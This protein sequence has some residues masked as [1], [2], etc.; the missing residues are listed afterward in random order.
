MTDAGGATCH[1]MEQLR[2]SSQ[3]RLDVVSAQAASM[4]EKLRGNAGGGSEG[5][6]GGVGGASGAPRLPGIR[7]TRLAHGGTSL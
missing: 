7:G 2:H 1:Q 3:E 4:M 5:G 6:S